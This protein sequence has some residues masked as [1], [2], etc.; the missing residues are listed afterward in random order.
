MLKDCCRIA[1]NTVV[2]PET[3]VPPFAVMSGAPARHTTDLPEA[4]P[5]LMVDY[6]R[7]LYNHFIMVKDQPDKRPDATA[8]LVEL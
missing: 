3:V 4:T 6:T 1:D 8:K 2:P 5:D 7:S